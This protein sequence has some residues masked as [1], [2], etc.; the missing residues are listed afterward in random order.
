MLMPVP[1]V[2]VSCQAAGTPPNIIT[3]A[4]AGTVCSHPPMVG[5]AIMPSRHSHGLIQSGGEFVVNI[6]SVHQARAT[7]QCGVWS[8]RDVDKF[9][10]AGLTAVPASRVGPPLIAECPIHLECCVRRVIPLGSHD[11]FLAEIVAVQVD[12]RLVT[13]GGR[14]AIEAAGLLAYAHG[15]YYA[16]GRQIG[17]FGF[18]V[19][20]Q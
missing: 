5:I 2:M 8:G 12:S 6:P 9:S 14:L 4:W 20:K 13:K 19:R 15:H 10:R 16:M 7:D 18:A 3:V 11:L 17:R 1:A